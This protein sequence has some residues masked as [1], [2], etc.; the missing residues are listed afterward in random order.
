MKM[1]HGTPRIWP[2]LF[3]AVFFVAL[4]LC[5]QTDDKT[6]AANPARPTFANPATLTPVGYLQFEQGYLGSLASPETAAQYGV[7]QVTKLTVHPRLMFQVQ[8]QP[9]AASKA[10]GDTGYTNGSGDVLLGAQAVLWT[11]SGGSDSGEASS[12][13][14][15]KTPVPTVSLGYLGR[16]H[17]GNTG[18]IDLGSYSKS[19]VLLLSG[20]V[21]GFHYDTNYLV[22]EQSDGIVRRA[23][24]AQTLS[25]N[26]SVI[27]NNLQ[28][29]VE[30]YHLTQPLV[31]NDDAGRAV[32]RA[33]M[34]DLLIAPSYQFAP[35]LIVDFGF[36]RGLTSTSTRWQSFVGFTYVLPHR[37]WPE[38]KT[39]G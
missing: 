20:D 37:L 39:K 33:N 4:P 25:V 2:Q 38:H 14:D 3:A 24:F 16:V 30:L 28:I 34:V 7:N 31:T 19:V 18:D 8:T 32:S 5:A 13:A 35:N 6:P 27:N 17:T 26:H 22:N 9:Y 21:H 29:A 15:K 23:Q 36:T 12:S 1:A 10:V 11:P